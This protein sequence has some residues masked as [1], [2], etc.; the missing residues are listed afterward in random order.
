MFYLF[1]TSSRSSEPIPEYLLGIVEKPSTQEGPLKV[2][3][4]KFSKTIFNFK[5]PQMLM[6]KNHESTNF[7]I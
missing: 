7:A 3:Y 2:N 4:H 1:C 6:F 5:P